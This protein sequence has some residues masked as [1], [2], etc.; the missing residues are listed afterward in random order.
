VDVVKEEG[1]DVTKAAFDVVT[2]N[3]QGP[4]LHFELALRGGHLQGT[5]KASQDGRTLEAKIDLERIK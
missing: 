5:A 4:V 3:G 2:D 1:K